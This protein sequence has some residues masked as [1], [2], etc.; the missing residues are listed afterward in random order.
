V[1]LL[2]T[3]VVM[4]REKDR[5]NSSGLVDAKYATVCPKTAAVKAV[6]TPVDLQKQKD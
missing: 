4:M 3:A 6:Q 1:Q 5:I 2:F